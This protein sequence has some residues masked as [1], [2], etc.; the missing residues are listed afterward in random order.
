MIKG[1]II[2]RDD[3]RISPPLSSRYS[4]DRMCAALNR[5]SHSDAYWVAY[6]EEA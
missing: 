2:Y 6:Q 3:R 4:A 5:L 1:W